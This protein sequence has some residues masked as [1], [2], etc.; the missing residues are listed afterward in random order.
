M[1]DYSKIEKPKRS[2]KTYKWICQSCVG[3]PAFRLAGAK[4]NC[5]LCGGF[6]DIVGRYVYQNGSWVAHV[7]TM[8]LPLSQEAEDSIDWK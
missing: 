1:I 4:Q 6:T 7:P 2:K 8:G 5:E 3:I